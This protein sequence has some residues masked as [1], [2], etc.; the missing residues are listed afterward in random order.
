MGYSKPS[1]LSISMD[2]S[3]WDIADVQGRPPPSPHLATL[4]ATN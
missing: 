3:P 2:V 1:M 4:K